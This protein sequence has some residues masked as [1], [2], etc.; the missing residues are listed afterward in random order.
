MLSLKGLF[1]HWE[2]N[3]QSKDSIAAECE[4]QWQQ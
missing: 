4:Q 3:C 2:E 1:C